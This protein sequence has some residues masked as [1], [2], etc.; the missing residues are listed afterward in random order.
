MAIEKVSINPTS[1]LPS[2]LTGLCTQGDT[3]KSRVVHISGE[4]MLTLREQEEPVLFK[5]YDYYDIHDFVH[6]KEQNCFHLS[7]YVSFLEERKR[8]SFKAHFFQKASGA[9]IGDVDFPVIESA[10]KGYAHQYIDSTGIDPQD[11][12][13]MVEGM[14]EHANGTQ[15][16]LAAS[17]RSCAFSNV[18]LNPQYTH[19]YPKKEPVTIAFGEYRKDWDD[20]PGSYTHDPN[21]IV[22]S[23]RRR[24]QD[25]GDSDYVCNYSPYTAYP[26]VAIPVKGIIRLGRSVRINGVILDPV[27][28]VTIE[29]ITGGGVAITNT[30]FTSTQPQSGDL[31]YEFATDWGTTIEQEGGLKPYDYNIKV[32]FGIEYK[33]AAGETQQLA[34]MVTS[35]SVLP[36]SSSTNLTHV[37]LPLRIM[38][39]CLAR[40]TRVLTTSG[41]VLIEEIKVGDTLAGSDGN[42]SVSVRNIW[43]GE[44]AGM[45]KV[46]YDGKSIL[47]TKHHPVY[48]LEGGRLVVKRAD[49]L[50]VSDV[51][52]GI[53]GKS[54]DI[55]AIEKVAYNDTV[56]NLSLNGGSGFF[57][58]DIFV[59][60]M[61][62]QNNI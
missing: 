58:N 57:A 42:K 26:N 4:K 7:M 56:Y 29:P 3:G 41:E 59:G 20:T 60:D 5:F 48:V 37:I 40:G 50:T 49:A 21:H 8:I 44:E 24:P 25:S 53:E 47:L 17:R 34:F 16:R 18:E 11:I 38:W 22:V 9:Y 33:L 6:M 19:I 2:H 52:P 15:T 10:Q 39:G 54:Y 14:V 32:G 35:E 62:T 31:Q 43:T 51:L 27:P 12:T 23:L 55:T 13:V 28:Y 61:D 45:I 36:M 46:L 30:K 1:S